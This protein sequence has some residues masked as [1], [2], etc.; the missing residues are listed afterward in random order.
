MVPGETFT[1]IDIGSSKIKTII[2][3]FT[4]DKKLRVLGV[5]V[6]ASGGVRKGNILDMD[7][8]K[9]NVDASLLEAEKMTGEETRS[10]YLCV[11]GTSIDSVV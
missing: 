11:S 9:K 4:E 5:G 6:S 7:E 1:A 8:F 2:G 10:V 3:T